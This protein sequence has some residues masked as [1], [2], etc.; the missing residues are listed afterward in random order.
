[1]QRNGTSSTLD[2]ARKEKDSTLGMSDDMPK[3]TSNHHGFPETGNPLRGSRPYLGPPYPRPPPEPP[4]GDARA[5]AWNVLYEQGVRD[6]PGARFAGTLQREDDRS[7]ATVE[8]NEDSRSLP[9]YHH[10]QHNRVITTNAGVQMDPKERKRVCS[11][12]FMLFE[13][14][15]NC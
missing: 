2:S 14:Y 1:M 7:G 12:T 8:E 3:Q 15:T 6:D 9:S 4:T 13:L 10:N 11:V 5:R